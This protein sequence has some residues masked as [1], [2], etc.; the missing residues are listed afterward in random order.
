[1]TDRIARLLDAQRDFVA[2]ASHQ[3]RTPLTG[4]RLRLEEA[5]ASGRQ[6]RRRRASSTRASPRSTDSRRSSS[7]LLVLSRAG[8]REPR[9]E[10]G[11][12]STTSRPR[13]VA[14]WTAA[15]RPTRASRSST[16][17]SSPAGLRLGGAAD[18]DRA[19][20]A[21]IEN[22]LQLLAAGARVTVVS[23]PGRDRGPRPRPRHRRGRARARVRALPPRAAPD[24]R[25]AR[26]RPRAADRAR[27]RPRLGRLHRDHRSRGG[28]HARQRSTCPRGRAGATRTRSRRLCRPLTRRT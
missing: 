7:E 3:L 15:R 10:R 27:A 11:S 20:D 1:M 25:P 8:E 9:S 18:V 24:A 28:R 14:R 4:L 5:R 21:L 16:R 23:A 2:D 19:L 6:P 26:Q 13:R 22:A 17:P 12:T